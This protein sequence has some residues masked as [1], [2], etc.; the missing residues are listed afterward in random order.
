MRPP[1]FVIPALLTRM[2]IR[3]QRSTPSSIM[4]PTESRVLRSQTTHSA[5]PP[6]V[7]ARSGDEGCSLCVFAHCR[8][9]E[10][11]V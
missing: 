7:F 3:P 1:S 2:S 6:D 5:L 9:S 4:G 11:S 10:L 8:C